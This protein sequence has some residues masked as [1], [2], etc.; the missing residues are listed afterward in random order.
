M[1]L[2][3][4]KPFFWLTLLM[5]IL[6]IPI[7]VYYKSTK[8]LQISDETLPVLGGSGFFWGSNVEQVWATKNYWFWAIKASLYLCIIC[9]ST[10]TTNLTFVVLLTY[11]FRGK[12]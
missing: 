4:R 10:N 11:Y 8:C 3:H 7:V 2:K 5:D 12:L 1:Y 6:Y 9:K